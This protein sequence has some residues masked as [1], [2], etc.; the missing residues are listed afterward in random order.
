MILPFSFF[1]IVSQKLVT[2]ETRLYLS[3]R[4]VE[5]DFVTT[6]S[7]VLRNGHALGTTK[8]GPNQAI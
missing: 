8:V 1:E 5:S 7:E 3:K 6:W 2:T 4:F